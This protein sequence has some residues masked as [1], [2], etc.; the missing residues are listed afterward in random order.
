MK[1]LLPPDSLLVVGGR[2]AA[3]YDDALLEVGGRR[4]ADMAEFRSELARLAGRPQ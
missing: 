1:A 4:I 3:H 2:A